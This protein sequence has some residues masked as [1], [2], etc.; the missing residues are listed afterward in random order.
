MSPLRASVLESFFVEQIPTPSI[1]RMHVHRRRR[2]ACSAAPLGLAFLLEA[3]QVKADVSRFGGGVGERDRMVER[4]TRLVRAVEL[5][6]ECAFEAEEIKVA[7]EL[8]GQR[9]DH[10]QG[11]RW[12]VELGDSDGAIESDDGR[13]L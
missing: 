10:R 2:A 11:V 13:G 7:A 12:P 4:G 5:G 8:R 9:L 3:I 6:E 1:S